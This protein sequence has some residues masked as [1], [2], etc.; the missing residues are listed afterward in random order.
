M[1]KPP[2]TAPV[3]LPRNR[4]TSRRTARVLSCFFC[5]FILSPQMV[6]RGRVPSS[7]ADVDA[8]RASAVRDLP[9]G[10]AAGGLAA[11]AAAGRTDRRDAAVAAVHAGRGAAE[12]ADDFA[13]H[14]KALVF[15]LLRLLHTRLRLLFDWL[16]QY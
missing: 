15:L 10:R 3:L 1:Q 12:E 16:S 14:G 9:A 7:I 5:F 13:L 11:V 6:V 4:T 2:A 8:V